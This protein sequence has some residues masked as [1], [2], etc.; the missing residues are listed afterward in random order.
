MRTLAIS[1]LRRCRTGADRSSDSTSESGF[2]T[3][4]LAARRLSTQS[5]SKIPQ[6]MKLL[7]IQ[8]FTE[9]DRLGQLLKTY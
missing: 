1:S 4:S 5:G 2:Q 7:P 6:R 9:H 3:R 8:L